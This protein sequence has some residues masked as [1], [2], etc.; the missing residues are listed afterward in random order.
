VSESLLLPFTKF[1]LNRKSWNLE[2]KTPVKIKKIQIQ[3]IYVHNSLM[4]SYKSNARIDK[5]RN[6][7]VCHPVM[8]FKYIITE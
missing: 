2:T 1:F 3:T 8:F 5:R 4:D 6:F 7:K